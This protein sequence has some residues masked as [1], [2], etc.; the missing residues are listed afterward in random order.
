MFLFYF[1]FACLDALTWN[2]DGLQTFTMCVLPMS[3]AIVLAIVFGVTFIF[4]STRAA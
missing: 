4:L 3:L 2:A 1:F